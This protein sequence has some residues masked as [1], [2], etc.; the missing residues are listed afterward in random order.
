[1]RYRSSWPSPMRYRNRK[2]QVFSPLCL[3]PRVEFLQCDIGIASRAIDLPL[4]F[5][6]RWIPP[7][8]YR[9]RIITSPLYR[10]SLVPS[11]TWYHDFPSAIQLTP[12]SNNLY[13][14]RT[15]LYR[16]LSLYRKSSLYHKSSLY[17]KSSL[18]RKSPYRIHFIAITYIAIIF[19]YRIIATI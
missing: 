8:R 2:S 4:F 14:Y 18:Y 6:S 11:R 1:M 5:L 13:S 10:I 9:Y 16:K 17:C 3:F 12:A 19:H 15:P 7:M